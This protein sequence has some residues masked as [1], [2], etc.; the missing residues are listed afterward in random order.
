MT[1]AT[2]SA[3]TMPAFSARPLSDLQ[4]AVAGN[5]LRMAGAA[6]AYDWYTQGQLPL[7]VTVAFFLD[8]IVAGLLA[9]AAA[10]GLRRGGAWLWESRMFAVASLASFTNL[11]AQVVSVMG[12][13]P[14]DVAVLF[15]GMP[16]VAVMAGAALSLGCSV[17]ILAGKR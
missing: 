9:P 1:T 5:L 8:G 3:L 14:Q 17:A 10:A 12:E 6:A 13:F 16:S 7:M 15:S 2:A 4:M 11:A